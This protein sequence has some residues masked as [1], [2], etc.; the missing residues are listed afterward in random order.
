MALTRRQFLAASALV[1]ATV[2][3]A[4]AA[5]ATT[6]DVTIQGMAFTPDSL[7]ISAGDTVRFTNMDGAPHTATS[8]TAG[9]DTGRLR[10]GDT[11]E[12]TFSTAGTFPYVC[13]IHASMHGTVIVQA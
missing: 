11:A 1:P 9:L 8:A 7:T 10:R 2:G 6:H 4:T 12:L 5:S 13:A 3:F